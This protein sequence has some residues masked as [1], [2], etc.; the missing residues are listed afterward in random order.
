MECKLETKT[1][2][3]TI[4]GD[5]KHIPHVIFNVDEAR[6]GGCYI[7]TVAEARS[8]VRQMREIGDCN[9]LARQFNIYTKATDAKIRILGDLWICSSIMAILANTMRQNGKLGVHLAIKIQN[10]SDLGWNLINAITS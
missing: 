3:N 7:F 2:L 8:L 1:R 10:L 9:R 6:L 4:R 5:L